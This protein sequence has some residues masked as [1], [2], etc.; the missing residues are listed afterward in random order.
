M[1]KINAFQYPLFSVIILP[2]IMGISLTFNPPPS[3]KSL[4][5]TSVDSGTAPFTF[6]KKRRISTEEYHFAL[7]LFPRK[8]PK[9]GD[10][11]ITDGDC[12]GNPCVVPD[13]KGN[14]LVKMKEYYENPLSVPSL[15]AHELTHVWQYE[16]FGLTWYTNEFLKNHVFCTNDPYKLNCNEERKLAHYNAEQQG[17]LVSMHYQNDECASKVVV[18]AVGTKTWHL[19]IGSSGRD[20]TIDE[21]GKMYLTNAAGYIYR[22][23]GK[24]WNRMPGSD[25]S[26]IAANAKPVDHAENN[27]QATPNP[28]INIGKARVVL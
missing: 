10:V 8:F 25:G 22:Y 7:K 13:G 3:I 18:K 9:Q 24:K 12:L 21:S 17:Q 27:P 19:M 11:Y 1:K 15:F 16:H 2:F 14:L 4:E 6:G 26:T 28:G 20:I 5:E 23:D